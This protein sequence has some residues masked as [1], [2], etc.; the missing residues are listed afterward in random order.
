MTMLM[1]EETIICLA[2]RSEDPT[3]IYGTLVGV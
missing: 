2:C 3:T 1:G